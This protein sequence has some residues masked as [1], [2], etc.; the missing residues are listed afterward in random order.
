MK[1][2]VLNKRS[3]YIVLFA[4]LILAVSCR[5][6]SSNKTNVNQS[7]EASK[8]VIRLGYRQRILGDPTPPVIKELFPENKD[9]SVELVQISNIPDGFNKLSAKE[10]DAFA[11]I[12]LEALMQQVAGNSPTPA[13]Y[14]YAFSVDRAGDEW[15]GLIAH[16]DSGIKS[17]KDAAG[18]IA[19][20]APTDQGE[21]LVRQI[22]T[23]GGVPPDQ[24]KIIRHSAQNPLLQFKTG[25]ASLILTAEPVISQA[26]AEGH[27]ILEKGPIS[28]YLFDGRDVV[29]SGSVMSREFAAKHPDAVK[30]FTETVFKAGD[31]MRAEP[32]KTRDLF[33]QEQYGALPPEVRSRFAFAIM[34]KPDAKL[35]ES[36]ADFAN[37]LLRDGVL[38]QPADVS[39]L[40]RPEDIGGN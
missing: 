28:K 32:Q 10:I 22:L 38:K 14:T 15:V 1:L 26:L 3:I 16:K 17:I 29:V 30:S 6:D 8:P 5:Y 11:G 40:V 18:K 27:Y 20:S 35:K 7:A 36:M 9:Y 37:R 33:A 25:E 31:L 21:W 39:K 12:P 19:L 24:I 4:L 23:A 13:Y 2:S 34:A